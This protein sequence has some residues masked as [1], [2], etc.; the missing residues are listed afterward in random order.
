M[1][2]PLTQ[3]EYIHATL[4]E[5]GNGNIDID[6]VENSIEIVEQMREPYLEAERS[7]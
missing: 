1:N 6:M 2:T 7:D 3:L 4:E 5:C